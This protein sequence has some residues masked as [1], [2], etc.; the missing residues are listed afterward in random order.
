MAPTPDGAYLRTLLVTGD[1]EQASLVRAELLQAE[2]ERR[3][4]H[5]QS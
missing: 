3:I 5:G 1:E 4:E 2:W